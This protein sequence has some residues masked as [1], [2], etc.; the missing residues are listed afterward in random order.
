VRPEHVRSR[1]LL[2]PNARG[3]ALSDMALAMLVR[4][5]ARE[6]LAEDEPP[7]WRD[8][9]GRMIVPHGFRSSFRDW[10]G[11]TRPEGAR[12]CRACAGACRARR[13]ERLVAICP[14]VDRVGIML[15]P[16]LGGSG[17]EA[18]IRIEMARSLAKMLAKAA[19]EAEAATR[20]VR[21]REFM[22]AERAERRRQV[23]AEKAAAA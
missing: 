8:V 15:A 16:E 21:A 2:F 18:T 12:S 9:T 5:M 23:R 10:C 6:G 13:R 7:R 19:D 1:D 11:E 20:R 14:N 17:E 3:D 4:G 22:A